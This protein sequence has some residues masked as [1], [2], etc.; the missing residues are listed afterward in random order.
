ML[1]KIYLLLFLLIYFSY[2]D[3]I[4]LE[5]IYL[6]NL[7]EGYKNVFRDFLIK[8]FNIDEKSKN[9]VFLHISWTGLSYNVCFNFKFFDKTEKISCFS[10]KSGEDFYEKVFS[11]LKDLKKREPHIKFVSLPVKIIGNVTTKKIRLVSEKR[12]ILVSY[13]SYRK[14]NKK[15]FVIG[16]IN[17][18]TVN[19]NNEHASKLLRFLLQGNKIKEILIIK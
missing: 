15:P 17:I 5:K 13:K 9:I 14:S 18:D 19:L 4:K 3:S 16:T 7:P 11:L 12:D 2:G 6:E 10:A 8:N 1:K